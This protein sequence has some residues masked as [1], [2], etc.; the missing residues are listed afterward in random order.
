MAEFPGNSTTLDARL[1]SEV[2]GWFGRHARPLPWRTTPRDPWLSLMSEI[3]LQQTQAARVAERFDAFRR[4]FP[5]PAAMA[6]AP[7]D[8]VL[9]LWS[10]LG[11][12]RR[13]GMLHACA[14]AIVARH[15]G[16]VPEQPKA[17]LA[18]PGVG[19]YTAGAV[20]SIVFGQP[21]PIVDG[22]VARVFLRIHGIERSPDEPS[23]QKWSWDRAAALAHAAGN[24]IQGYSE[25][26]MELGATVCTPTA[27]NCDA[28]PCSAFCT[29]RQLG[30]TDRIPRPKTRPARKP[31]AMSAIVV[32]D[33]RGRVLLEQRP[34]KGLWAGL[35]QP[36]TLERHGVRPPAI[37]ATMRELDLDGLV[38][39]IGKPTRLEMA[40]THRTIIARVSS[41]RAVNAGAVLKRR[42]GH[43]TNLCWV[44]PDEMEGFG[45]GSAQRRM[46]ELI[47]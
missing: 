4:A 38:E 6:G 27:P 12:Y 3:L 44:S 30:L 26:V 47:V 16:H 19:R 37:G 24:Q 46:L 14:K 11:Y 33:R 1:A 32:F 36:P 15:G 22:N 18:L 41:A 39:V 5:T 7:L 42:S 10:G 21:E 25:G 13:A 17:L 9:A 31:L 43:A 8:K 40:T 34:E 2:A 28:C 45:L 29:A 20:A 23:V 35:W